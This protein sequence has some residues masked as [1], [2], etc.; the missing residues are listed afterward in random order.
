MIFVTNKNTKVKEV[1]ELVAYVR[2]HGKDAAVGTVELDGKKSFIKFQSYSTDPRED[3][4]YETHE[5][6]LDVQFI[7]EGEETIEVTTKDGLSHT[8]YNDVKDVTFYGNEKR[9]VDYNLKA[10]DFIVVYPDEVHKP[11]I[12][13]NGPCA[14][15]KA[16]GKILL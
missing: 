3:C 10:G 2:E 6:Y 1:E 14:V 4:K 15:K 8:P 13:T 7:I 9:G 11:K 12:A 5:R 16:V